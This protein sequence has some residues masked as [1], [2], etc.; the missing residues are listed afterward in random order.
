MESCNSQADPSVFTVCLGPRAAGQHGSCAAG[1]RT[2]ASSRHPCCPPRVGMVDPVPC[3][4]SPRSSPGSR[5]SRRAF[6]RVG[7]G[8]VGGWVGGGCGLAG[9]QLARDSGG[10]RLEDAPSS[11]STRSRSLPL[12]RIPAVVDKSG[13]LVASSSSAKPLY[14]YAMKVRAGARAALVVAASP[15]PDSAP[16]G[17]KSC[18]ELASG[19]AISLPLL[20]GAADQDAPPRSA[21]DQ[22]C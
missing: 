15:T 16:C 1:C 20:W 18:V 4:T 17:C 7:V 10:G 22:V 14:N 11:L 12:A 2:C 8:G 19:A 13:N 5:T 6:P 21:A 3:R 9:G